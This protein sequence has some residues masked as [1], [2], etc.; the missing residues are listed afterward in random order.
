[1]QCKRCGREGVEPYPSNPGICVECAKAEN[2][3]YSSLR[4]HQTDW[5]V[6]AQEAGIDPWEQQPG[7]TQWEYTVWTAYRDSYPGKRPSYSDVAKLLDTTYE[8]VKKVAQRW[9]FPVRMQKW[10]RFVDTSTLAQRKQDMLDMNR[11]QI[12]MAKLANDKIN[13]ALAAL[14][15]ELMKPSEI[16]SLMKIAAELE[17]KA[18]VDTEAQEEAIRDIHEDPEAKRNKKPA[19]VQDLSEVATI[20]ANAGVLKVTQTTTTEVKVDNPIESEVIEEN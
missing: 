8:V 18:R 7:E 11:R 16:A 20:L 4:R 14:Q 15:P 6:V 19:N 1:M 9:T 13:A 2:N 3:R 12:D 17:R 10:M 5:L